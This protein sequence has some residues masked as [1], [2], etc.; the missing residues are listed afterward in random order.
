MRE[1]RDIAHGERR[2]VEED[3]ES[4]E[5]GALAGEG[6]GRG[7][8]PGVLTS[9]KRR[10]MVEGFVRRL[11]SPDEKDAAYRELAR[12]PAELI[13]DLI[14]EVENPL[15]SQMYVLDILVFQDDF[16]R[17]DEKEKRFYYFIKGLGQFE[18]DDIAIGKIRRGRWGNKV[19]LKN[20]TKG[21]P[22]GLVLRAAMLNRFR[23]R[24]LPVQ[25]DSDVKSWWREYYRRA[26]SHL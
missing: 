17:F 12:V 19:R 11:R 3:V 20:Y 9:K 2:G 1:T 25:D 16:T 23:S 10:A 15:S 18:L 13:P 6:R 5:L 14:E 26:K 22:V 8:G 4:T 21:F 7:S 24:R